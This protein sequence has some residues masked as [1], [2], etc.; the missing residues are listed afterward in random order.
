MEAKHSIKF[1]NHGEFVEHQTRVPVTGISHCGSGE[2][3]GK[4]Y[5]TITFYTF[6]DCEKYW[7]DAFFNEPDFKTKVVGKTIIYW[8]VDKR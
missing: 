3:D 5:G 7:I 1:L 2:K 4:T 8:A 6:D